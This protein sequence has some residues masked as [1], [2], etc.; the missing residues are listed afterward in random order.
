[1]VVAG[2]GAAFS[3]LSR[4]LDT[5][6]VRRPRRRRAGV[7]REAG[8]SEN[9][10][11][12]RPDVRN[13]AP[14]RC[15]SQPGDRRRSQGGLHPI[16]RERGI[17]SDTHSADPRPPDGDAAGLSEEEARRIAALL[18]LGPAL[19]GAGDTPGDHV[20]LAE[21][22]V[23]AAA[24]GRD[25]RGVGLPRHLTRCPVCLDLY[26]TLLDHVPAVARESRDR[27]VRLGAGGVA[28]ASGR[29]GHWPIHRLVAA[30]AC[31]AVLL[32]AGYGLRHL[33]FPDPPRSVGG[34]CRLAGGGTLEPG[35]AIPARARLVVEA[36]TTLHLDDGGTAVRAERESSVSFSR[37]LRGHPVFHVHEGDVHV[38]AA[39]QRPGMSVHVWTPLGGITVIGTEF[40]VRVGSEPIVIH[41]VRPDAPLAAAYEDRVATVAVAVTEGTVAVSTTRDRRLVTAGRSA[42]LRQGQ[43]LIEVR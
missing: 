37:S 10:P 29:G 6:P 3:F 16:F 38:M 4:T 42:V 2:Y 9:P 19:A 36:G 20:A 33:A 27:F 14:V 41:E 23:L 18:R 21:L 31:V 15:K 13:P 24:R 25:P 17:V 35:H 30:A 28:R 43:P 8:T 5:I 26:E 40:H 11:S 32:T 34:S 12:G 39:R 22:E 7:D 1:M